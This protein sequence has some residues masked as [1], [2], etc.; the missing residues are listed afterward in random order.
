VSKIIPVAKKSEP[1]EFGD[2]RPI[3]KLPASSK[4]MEVLMWSQTVF[5][6]N[7]HYLL[8]PFQSSFWAN[9]S[10]AYAFLKIAGGIQMNCY[11]RLLMVL[12][13]LDFS[14]FLLLSKLSLYLGDAISL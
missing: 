2:Y 13:L 6:V 12:L 3:S 1:C 4:A 11:R 5:F 8:D 7:S 10:T 14:K 9:H